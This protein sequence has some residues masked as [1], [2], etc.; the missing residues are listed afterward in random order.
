[1]SRLPIE[2]YLIELIQRMDTENIAVTIAGGLGIYLKHRW[3]QEQV[4]SGLRKNLFAEIPDARATD[5][6]DAFFQLEVYFQ[7][8]RSE[9]RRVLAELGYH[10]SVNYL[11]FEKPLSDGSDHTVGL[12][13][14]APIVVDPRLKA[15]KP[16]KPGKLRRLGPIDNKDSPPHEQLHAFATP[17]AFAIEE[18]PQ[19]LPLR[20]RTPAGDPYDG[21][22]R[23]PHPFASLCMKIKA[24]ADFEHA[25]LSER[26]PRAEK[27]ARDVYLLLAMLDEREWNECNELREQFSAHPELQAICAAV[28]GLFAAPDRAG[29]ITVA[30][31]TPEADLRRLSE[32]IRE[33]FPAPPV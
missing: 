17:E 2:P 11:I 8:T 31:N 27:H 21:H 12:D 23:I 3:V 7:P 25:P 19:A 18:R 20:G 24:A 1:M 22:V 10:P 28:T 13:L 14:L 9:F 30:R 15:D 26:K 6:I 33:L 32:V 4:K 16:G 5:D 29:C